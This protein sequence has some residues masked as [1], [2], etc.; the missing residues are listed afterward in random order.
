MLPICQ[1][2]FLSSGGVRDLF[3]WILRMMST[4]ALKTW[5]L[6]M[7][8]NPPSRVNVSDMADI[9]FNA[10]PQRSSA[11]TSNPNIPYVYAFIIGQKEWK[12]AALAHLHCLLIPCYSKTHHSWLIS[13]RIRHKKVPIR[14]PVTTVH[15]FQTL[16]YYLRKTPD[17][18]LMHIRI[19]PSLSTIIQGLNSCMFVPSSGNFS[20]KSF[21]TCSCRP[22]H[23]SP[24]VRNAAV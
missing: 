11:D 7:D 1:A 6:R 8:V 3:V 14:P 13:H 17:I 24:L 4:P 15:H 22:V 2:A 10:M 9:H 16:F 12:Y 18:V 21:S 5:G 19:L 23:Q 20:F